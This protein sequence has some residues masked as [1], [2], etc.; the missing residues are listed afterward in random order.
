MAK[1][2]TWG[3]S[4]ICRRHMDI[5]MSSNE[6][7]AGSGRIKSGWQE[8][9]INATIIAKIVGKIAKKSAEMG[10]NHVF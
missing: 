5:L 8:S 6:I 4:M 1:S 9:E 10:S 2:F 7:S 3:L